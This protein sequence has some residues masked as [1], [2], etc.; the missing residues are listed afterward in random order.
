MEHPKQPVAA[1]HRTAHALVPRAT[2][3]LRVT[4]AKLITIKAV[5][6][7]LLAAYVTRQVQSVARIV[8]A[9]QIVFARVMLAIVDLRVQHA[10]VGMDFM[11]VYVS[12]VMTHN[13]ITTTIRIPPVQ[14]IL[15][16]LAKGSY[17]VA[18][19]TRKGDVNR[20]V[21]MI[22]PAQIHRVSVKNLLFVL[23][24]KRSFLLETHHMTVHAKIVLKEPY[25]HPIIN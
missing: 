6:R 20:V 18:R 4:N 23:R 1:V 5:T 22:S 8:A 10:P 25:L 21:T 13:I 14:L 2:L 12:A 17:I 3:D 19:L 16:L 24:E 7:V 15:V 9:L 11:T